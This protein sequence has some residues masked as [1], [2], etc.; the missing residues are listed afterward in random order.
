MLAIFRTRSEFVDGSSLVSSQVPVIVGV[1]W[2]LRLLCA[3]RSD[4]NLPSFTYAV[5]Y[6]N[7]KSM[8]AHIL[9]IS[10]NVS[11][12]QSDHSSLSKSAQCGSFSHIRGT[13]PTFNARE[14][15][16]DG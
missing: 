16:V 2:L 3:C 15:A 14:P 1:R 8:S 9:Q 11:T 4:L 5:Y 12:G 10:G 6:L 7:R 13:K